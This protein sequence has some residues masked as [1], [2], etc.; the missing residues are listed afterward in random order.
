MGN[1]RY[2]YI[3]RVHASQLTSVTLTA[4]EDS[5]LKSVW[6]SDVY[7]Q[8]PNSRSIATNKERDTNTSGAFCKTN[9]QTKFPSRSDWSTFAHTRLCWGP[10]PC[11][12]ETADLREWAL[13][14][15]CRSPPG[16]WSWWRGSRSDA[17]TTPLCESEC[18]GVRLGYTTNRC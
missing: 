2:L 18:G 8:S 14:S 1:F 16:P 11:P 10:S 12:R 7:S 6:L 15:L 13:P 3:K 4:E 5:S 17:P 9:D